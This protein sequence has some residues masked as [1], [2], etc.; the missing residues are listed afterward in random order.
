MR[1]I[2]EKFPEVLLVYG[3]NNVCKPPPKDGSNVQG[4]KSKLKFYSYSSNRQRFY[5]M[6]GFERRVA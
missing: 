3:T 1:P 5:R 6:E 2:F 4:I